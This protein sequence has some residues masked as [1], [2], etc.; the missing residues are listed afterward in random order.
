LETRYP[1]TALGLH[2][3]HASLTDVGCRREKNEDAL[4]FFSGGE[5]SV[6]YL[7]TIA[8]GV[9]GSAAGEIA[10]QLAVR[11]L[12]ES[13]FRDGDPPDL[14][15]ALRAALQAANAAV[16]A[17]AQGN[18]LHANMA[19]TCTAAAL[20][21]QELVIG[22]VGDCRAY[23]IDG[24][25]FRQLTADHSMAAEYLSRGEPLPADKQ[26]LANVLTRW[27]GSE[28]TLEPDIG[29]PY[30]MPENATLVLCS[31]GLTKVVA[32]TEIH[33]VV[34]IHMPQ[35]ACRRLVDMARERGGPDN[36]TVQ[37]ARLSRF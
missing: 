7:L 3:Y 36:I 33:E 11:A 5:G 2:L 23:L 27:L 29:G 4:G 37:I 21:G 13:F 9:G 24:R 8:D 10:S 20:R 31:D 26:R 16:L 32:E 25:D 18:P 22:H 14:A 28:G 35:G 12:G 34:A 19:T 15:A 1:T 17:D 30:L 6:T